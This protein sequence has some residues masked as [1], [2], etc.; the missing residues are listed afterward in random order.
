MEVVVD[1]AQFLQRMQYLLNY[2]LL[3]QVYYLGAQLL[4][5]LGGIEAWVVHNFIAV[6]FQT[7]RS[8]SIV[9]K[10]HI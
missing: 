10:M 7:I 5:V 1:A 9:C 6:L 4:L 8:K 2:R 3:N